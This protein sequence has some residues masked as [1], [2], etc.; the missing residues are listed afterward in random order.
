MIGAGA[1][2]LAL[3]ADAL[4][5]AC[6]A[7]LV[8]LAFTPG[9]PDAGFASTLLLV[10]AGF[11][12]PRLA[13]VLAEPRRAL[14]LASTAALA[15]V[16]TTT[17]LE[18]GRGLGVWSFGWVIDF[19]REPEATMR[20]GAPAV[21]VALLLAVA[22]ARG[23]ARAEQDLDLELHP[24]TMFLP[25]AIVVSSCVLAAG[26]SR[27]GELATLAAA[28]FAV[29]VASLAMAQLALGGST[30]GTVRSGGI[31]ATLLGATVVASLAVFLV[32]GVVSRWLGPVVVPPVTRVAEQVLIVLLTP[33]AWML[34]E[35]FQRLFHGVDPFQGLAPVLERTADGKGTEGS[36]SQTAAERVG[37]FG[38]RTL[39]LLLFGALLTGIVI[40][41]TR[42]RRRY[43]VLQ[44]RTAPAGRAGGLRDDLRDLWKGIFKGRAAGDRGEPAEEAARLYLAVLADAE[45]RGHPRDP[46][47]T[48]HEFLP[49][50]HETFET[51]VTDEITQLFEEA[52]YAGRTPDSNRLREVA[53]RWEEVRRGQLRAAP[54]PRRG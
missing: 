54:S 33:V 28:F 20:A 47:Q 45:R 19:Y 11:V 23:A 5:I 49:V 30:L 36:D 13:G 2:A 38:L 21:A 48:P 9:S 12:I 51:N 22:W 26:S 41:W 15:L 40:A 53:A 14:I 16:L 50:L 35:L 17:S 31:T 24:R 1:I 29:A 25:F 43:A 52:R 4:A 27:S 8:A 39:S 37:L 34:T 42:A 6:F 46:A 7:T 18:A 3:L 32:F 10:V 44:E